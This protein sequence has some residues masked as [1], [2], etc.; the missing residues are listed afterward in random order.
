MLE[1]LLTVTSTSLLL[2]LL[3]AQTLETPCRVLWSIHQVPV[4]EPLLQKRWHLRT[5]A[6]IEICHLV[7]SHHYWLFGKE[8][9]LETETERSSVICWKRV[10]RQGPAD[11]HRLSGKRIKLTPSQV[12]E[13]L[14]PSVFQCCQ[15]LCS[16]G[17]EEECSEC[18]DEVGTVGFGPE[19]LQEEFHF[20]KGLMSLLLNVDQQVISCFKT[21][22][23]KWAN[24]RSRSLTKTSHHALLFHPKSLFFYWQRG[25]SNVQQLAQ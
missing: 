9:I 16:A 8:I 13:L 17:C 22:F 24:T 11:W 25:S 14:W 1:N 6:L 21:N 20:K 19:C 10:W 18:R 2:R 7:Y 12:S 4:N 5:S 3:Q 23:S 15:T